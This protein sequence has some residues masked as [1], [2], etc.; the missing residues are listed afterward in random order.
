[1]SEREICNCA[2][3]IRIVVL[4][5]MC[6]AEEITRGLVPADCCC[7]IREKIILGRGLISAWYAI[8]SVLRVFR[9]ITVVT[10]VKII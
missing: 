10:S 1:M 6:V 7:C 3:G 8:R 5:D 9:I 4:H 2:M